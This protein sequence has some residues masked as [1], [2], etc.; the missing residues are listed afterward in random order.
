MRALIYDQ[1]PFVFGVKNKGAESNLA[2]RFV[3]Q[4][5]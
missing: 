4:S 3:Y 1:C 5:E 2:Y